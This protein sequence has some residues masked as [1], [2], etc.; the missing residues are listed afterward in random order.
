MGCYN[1]CL[2]NAPVDRVWSALR[3]FHDLSWAGGV[4]QS[5]ERIIKP[6]STPSRNISQ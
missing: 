5:V 4:V 3:N 1:S 2:V 6:C